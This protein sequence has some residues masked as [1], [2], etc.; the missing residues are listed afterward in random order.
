MPQ[1]F[2][3]YHKLNNISKSTAAFFKNCVITPIFLFFCTINFNKICSKRTQH[4]KYK[5]LTFKL[6]K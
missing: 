2:S 5:I 3:K 1:Q 4:I 6:L